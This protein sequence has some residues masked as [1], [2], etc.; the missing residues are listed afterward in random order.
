VL[1]GEVLLLGKGRSLQ[2]RLPLRVEQPATS[3]DAAGGVHA[4]AAAA[5]AAAVN[6]A[7]WL[8]QHDLSACR[9]K[10]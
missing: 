4:L 5:E 1:R 8:Q 10:P 7:V 6:I 9:S 3:P 2:A